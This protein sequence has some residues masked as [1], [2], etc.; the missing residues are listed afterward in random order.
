[1]LNRINNGAIHCIYEGFYED[2]LIKLREAERILSFA[3]GEGKNI[4][5]ALIMTVLHNEA[6]AFE[7]V[8]NLSELSRYL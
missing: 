4:S 2:A 8:Y 6:C 1:M 3:V 7:G 5:E